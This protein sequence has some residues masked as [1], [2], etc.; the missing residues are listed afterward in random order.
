[1]QNIFRVSPL[2]LLA[3]VATF[4]LTSCNKDTNVTPTS[5]GTLST[6]QFIVTAVDSIGTDSICILFDKHEFPHGAHR[7]SVA[8]TALLSTI[9]TYL[10]TNY[11]GYTFK[12]AFK[13]TTDS[14][15]AGGFVV[16]IQFNS[17]P[18]AL[19]FDTTGA[20]QSV[21]EQRDKHDLG[22]GPGFHEG[23]HFGNRDGMHHDTIAQADLLQAVKSYMS[24]NYPTDTFSKAFK[25]FNGDIVVITNNNGAFATEFK[26][27]GAFIKRITLPTPPQRGKHT[28]I[29][30]TALPTSVQ[31][32]FTTTYPNY[33]FDE[34]FSFNQN[35]TL[36]GY[37]VIIDANNTKY[38]VR[39]D[40]SGNFVEVKTIH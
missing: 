8:Q 23:G 21:L 30:Q 4:I 15:H 33:V 22:D 26:A 37:V 38:A 36:L 18:V 24:V 11:A 9:T 5:T 34:A 25:E 13:L 7:D 17:K 29:A 6:D 28:T 12:K 3:I 40:V 16:I 39:F 2:A 27:T 31:T 14:T 19:M 20:F 1:M 10:S 35:G 32:Y